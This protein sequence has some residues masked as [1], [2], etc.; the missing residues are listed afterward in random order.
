LATVWPEPAVGRDRR[1]NVEAVNAG[2]RARVFPPS[3]DWAALWA[4]PRAGRLGCFPR[5]RKPGRDG[6]GPLDFP[7]RP[8]AV[9]KKFIFH[10]LLLLLNENALENILAVI[11]ALKIVK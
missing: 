7:G 2:D 6:H 1:R 4:E 3:V 11:S 8:S 5:A 9:I 10:F